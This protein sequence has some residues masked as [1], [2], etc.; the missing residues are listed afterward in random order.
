MED[1][2]EQNDT[3]E[4]SEGLNDNPEMDT[5]DPMDASPSYDK[6]ENTPFKVEES[7]AAA[8]GSTVEMEGSN[9]DMVTDSALGDP[10]DVGLVSGA[11]EARQA[12]EML[13]GDDVANRVAAVQR[14]E[15]IATVLGERRT[16]EELVPF[17]RESVDDED[18]VLVA[19]AAALGKFIPFVGGKQYAYVILQPLELL[20]TVG[21]FI[22]YK[23]KAIHSVKLIKLN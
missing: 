15:S 1:A 10:M 14:L 4:T 23:F 18:E 5:N 20:L 21:K 12:I 11:E 3:L 8:G 17:L 13:R 9:T 22:Y 2:V 7:D 6:N 16:R 19:M